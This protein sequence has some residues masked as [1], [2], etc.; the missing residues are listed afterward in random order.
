MPELYD[1]R[2]PNSP[3]RA[4]LIGVKLRNNLMHEAEESLQ[5]LQQLAET[6]GIEVVYETIQSR[7]A[8]NPTYF[9]GEGKVEE[10]KP[11]VEE[12]DAD[13]IIFDE[14]LSPAQNRNLEKA[15]DVAT[16]DRTGLI[17]QVFAQRALTKE[18]RL[19]V[20]LAQLEYALPRLTRMWTHLSRLATGGGGGRHLRGPGETQLEMDRRWVRRNI[21]HVRK[22][23]E[24]VEKQRHTQRRNRSEKIKVSLVGYTNA[25][26]STLFNALTG[27]TVLAEDKLFATLDSTT[28][29]VDLP[30]KQQILLSDTVGFIK[31]LPHQLV[32]AFKATL[33]E[34]SEADLL[35]HVV[36][37]SHPEAEAQI[38]A[39]NVVLEE[40]DATHIPMFMVFNKIDRLKSEEGF[41]ILRSR[42][43]DALPI[44]AQRGDGIADLVD[45]LAHRFG[46]HG[47]NLSLSIPY[48]DG[49]V[50]DLLY[51]HGTVIDTEYTDKA[52]HVKVR[53]PSRYLKSV[54]QFLVSS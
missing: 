51:K 15:L 36:D 5:E 33:E 23:L 19:Q 17:L 21:G 48:I 34:V 40:L 53:L 41:Q 44:S 42:Y 16:I 24:A 11:L 32:A 14:E 22:A 29:K 4:I 25:G 54:S 7:N 28:R 13:A 39:V 50:L 10:L 31:K 2:A 37:V 3:S 26:K 43:P 12:L 46:E 47:T 20:A 18:A 9:I 27:E 30:Q 49:Q 52:I 38:A 6:A 1:T 8:P 45:A 35:L